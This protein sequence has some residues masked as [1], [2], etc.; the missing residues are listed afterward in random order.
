MATD[1]DIAKLA[2][3]I[4][5]PARA[6]M[7][8]DLLSGDA[9]SAT[10]LA[11]RADVAPATASAHLHRLIAGGLLRV[12]NRGRYRHYRLAGPEVAR[13]LEALGALAPR[14]RPGDRCKH[15]DARA[16][17]LAR[18]C[19]DH[20][21]GRLGVAIT[22]AL[23]QRGL[24]WDDGAAFQLTGDSKRWFTAFGVDVEAELRRRRAFARRCLDWSE[25]EPHLAGALGAALAARLCE[26]GWIER[27][28]GERLVVVTAAGQS[29]LRR[30][31]GIDVPR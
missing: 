12:E 21:A 18:I 9:L 13:V 20:V 25:R 22:T 1:P 4:G 31:L 7:L 23:V 15:E 14:S 5:A 28:E 30:E 17:R 29:G 27:I 16:L 11:A 10:E 26:A 2:A 6:A 3:L 19:Y 8:L 24:L